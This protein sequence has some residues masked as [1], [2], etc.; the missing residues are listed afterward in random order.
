MGTVAL[1]DVAQTRGGDGHRHAAGD[2]RL[3]EGDPAV[4]GRGAP[5]LRLLR[6]DEI[7]MRLVECALLRF[8]ARS[9]DNYD[10]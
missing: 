10:T 8:C 4:D 2:V 7:G 1:H 6:L 9:S 5:V 3:H